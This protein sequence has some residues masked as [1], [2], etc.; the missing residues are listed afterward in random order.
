MIEAAGGE[1]RVNSEVSEI[2]V[3]G[4]RAA[5]VRLKKT[6]Q[7][8]RAPAV[9][10][11]AG[12]RATYLRLLAPEVVPFRDEID[13]APVSM[14]HVSL[15]LGFSESPA[16][17]GATAAN[18]WAHGGLDHD[19]LFDRRNELLD[20]VVPHA[21]IFFPS[22]KDPAAR[23]HT[24]E[25]IAPIDATAFAAWAGTRWMKRGA[26]YLALKEHLSDALLA[27]AE[28]EFPGLSKLVV[29]RELSTPL[30]T[31]HFTGHR[32]GE[33]YG[34]PATPARFSKPY[35]SVRTPVPG[36]YMS[37]ADAFM[38]G[39]GGATVA[40]V[41]CAAA[42]AGL[43]VFPRLS[44]AASALPSPVWRGEPE[45]NQAALTP[46]SQAAHS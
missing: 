20:A 34:L 17:A 21:S 32:G 4:G 35:L 6:G 1:V 28:R 42:I 16:K 36:L 13:Q 2:V 19:R 10:S 46:H 37:G 40:S 15:Y 22:L 31:E 11:N 3:E 23:V 39:I 25:I 41:F 33:I 26:E 29:T 24:A 14:G 38:L 30:S 12:A 45:A 5:G 43:S 7:V 44:R 27:F 8:L 9:I 18:C